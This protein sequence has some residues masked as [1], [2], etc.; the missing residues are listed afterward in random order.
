M[1][2]STGLKAQEF[3]LVSISELGS[4]SSSASSSPAVALFSAEN[5]VAELRFQPESESAA[6]LNVDLQTAKVCFSYLDCC[7]DLIVSIGC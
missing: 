3:A 5:G 4:S 6:P 1:E 2:N 7:F